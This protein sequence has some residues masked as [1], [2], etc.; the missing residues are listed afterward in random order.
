MSN[1]NIAGK[2]VKVFILESS[3]AWIEQGIGSLEIIS[4]GDPLDD[5]KI[6]RVISQ[7]VEISELSDNPHQN[8]ENG[9]EFDKTKELLKS[10]IKK[11]YNFEKQKSNLLKIYKI[12]ENNIF[13]SDN[14][15]V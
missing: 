6:L 11:E 9:H 4:I 2:T 8:G 5:K 13:R 14:Y 10:E 3:G 7:E 15:L 1:L 12:S